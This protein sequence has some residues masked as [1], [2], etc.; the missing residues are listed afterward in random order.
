MVPLWMYPL[1]IA[2]G[3]TFILKPSEKV[4]LTAILLGQLLEQAGLPKGVLNIVHG[5]RPCVDA[6]LTHPKVRA[7]SFVGSTP[8]AKYIYETGTRHGKRVQANGGA[9]NYIVIMPDAD[10][11][12]TVEALSTAAFGCAGER[13]RDPFGK[14]PTCTRV[15]AAWGGLAEQQ[16]VAFLLN[17]GAR[18]GDRLFKRAWVAHPSVEPGHRLRGQR[19]RRAARRQHERFGKQQPRQG[20]HAPESAVTTLTEIEV[21]A[22]APEP[23]G[24]DRIA[25][26]AQD[27]HRWLLSRLPRLLL[28]LSSLSYPEHP[29]ILNPN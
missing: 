27:A 14:S 15:A 5:G 26:A 8:I 29:I 24:G 4:P 17:T 1:A 6:L 19:A 12:K 20:A 25:A 9:K 22:L 23:G 2:C 16:A 3:N 13:W 21:P 11:G 7:V 18:Q 28:P 10:I